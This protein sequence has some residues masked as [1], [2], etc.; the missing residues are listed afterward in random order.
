MIARSCVIELQVEEN[1]LVDDTL[2]SVIDFLSVNNSCYD[3]MQRNSGCLTCKIKD[4]GA[5]YV[6]PGGN[7]IGAN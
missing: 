4:E 7:F 3:D 2:A 1:K 5:A 6:V